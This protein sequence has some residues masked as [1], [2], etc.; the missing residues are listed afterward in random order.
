M[1]DPTAIRA[2]LDLGMSGLLLVGIWAL[3]TGKVVPGKDRDDWRDIARSQ[4]Q[5]F[6]RIANQLE[7]LIRRK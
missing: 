5:F 2:L 6:E 7:E 1:P 4:A 3:A